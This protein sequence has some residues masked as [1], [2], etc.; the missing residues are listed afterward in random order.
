MDSFPHRTA[1]LGIILLG[2]AA[3][4][5]G[6]NARAQESGYKQLTTASELSVLPRPPQAL[7][8]PLDCW[9][10]YGP[11]P[12]RYCLPGFGR[13]GYLYYGTHPY[14]DDWFNRFNDCP[15][16]NCGNSGTDL[17]LG[18]VQLHN[19]HP[20]PVNRFHQHHAR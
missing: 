11:P 14:D 7:L 13:R 2:I 6:A 16:G 5:V 17:G 1:P 9:H 3:A 20:G 19:V 15:G 10:C 4:L 8:P 18:W 12:M